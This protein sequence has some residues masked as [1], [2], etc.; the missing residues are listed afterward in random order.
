MFCVSLEMKKIVLISLCI[1]L[2]ACNKNR[3]ALP[4]VKTITHFQ[5]DSIQSDTLELKYTFT[6]LIQPLFLQLYVNNTVK[7]SITLGVGINYMASAV[8]VADGDS[9]AWKDGNQPIM[10]YLVV[11]SDNLGYITPFGWYLNL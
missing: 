10:P 1:V 5:T 11:D 3:R 9:V 6:P 8:I 4:P 7:D 2:F